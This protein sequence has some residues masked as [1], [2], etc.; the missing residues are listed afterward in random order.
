MQMLMV[1]VLS[2][3]RDNRLVHQ[4]ARKQWCDFRSG[5]PGWTVVMPSWHPRQE[6]QILSARATASKAMTTLSR[7][8][9]G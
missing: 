4:A 5:Q 9:L 1:R 3:R 2:L 7:S 8:Q 6:V